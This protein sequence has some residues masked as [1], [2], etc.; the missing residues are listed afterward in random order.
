MLTTL[1]N[2]ADVVKI[3]CLAQLV[4]ALAPI[5]TEPG[6]RAW[7]QTTYWPFYYTARHGHGAALR[8]AVDCPAYDCAAGSGIP[9][10]D[11][12]A[13]HDAQAGTITLFL[14]NKHLTED[15]SLQIK[16]LGPAKCQQWITLAGYDMEAT[17]TADSA[18][19]QPRT[20]KGTVIQNGCLY[21]CLEKASWNML[22]IKT[23]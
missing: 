10:V 17:N 5:M 12:A 16:G 22:V 7:A 14:V 8:A 21:A 23:E 13:V 19:V 1:I 20:A 11:C 4:N 2:N 3:A 6:G 15:I 18:P 9:C